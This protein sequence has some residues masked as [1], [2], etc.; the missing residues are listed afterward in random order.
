MA[1]G[2]QD[3]SRVKKVSPMR[4][5]RESSITHTEGRSIL[6]LNPG[7]GNEPYILATAIGREVSK[8][9]ASAG[10]EQPILVMPLFYGDRQRRILLEENPNDA[11][12]LYYDEQ[13]GGIL[14]DVMFE[15]G[16]F[17]Q[18]L[19][20]VNTHYDEVEKMLNNRYLVD[21][22]TVTAR[23]FAT[24]ESTELSPKNIIGVIEAGNRVPIK[25]P[26]RYFAFPEVLSRVLHEGM[27][28][29]ELGFSESDMKKLAKRMMKVEAAYSQVFVPWVST[30]SYQHAS[31][32]D[33]QPQSI[34]NRSRIYTPAMKANTAKTTGEV[35]QGVYIM[36]S[37]TGSAV[38]S[39]KALMHAAKEAGIKTYSPPWETIEGTEKMPP[40]VM[41][42]E[43][44]LAI[45]GRSGWGTGWQAMQLE[46]PWFV[47]P[48]QK[49]DDPEIYFNNKT[50]EALKLGK[51]IGSQEISGEELR[52]LAQEISPGLNS[53]ND[54]IRQK[55]G[56]T[57]GIDYIANHIFDDLVSKK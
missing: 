8:K 18:H 13:F 27:Q 54:A 32:L 57:N 16:D 53:L 44:I 46:K 2:E 28:H 35:D 34:D 11:S 55:F 20:Q 49:G 56:T 3:N 4:N 42:D 22:Q 26:H 41:A 23:S 21:T 31:G 47:A 50:I 37:G 51:V 38:E 36:F 17:K 10:M 5:L 29:P 9:F 15:S 40:S 43:N 6:V 14:K 52:R 48:Y 7:H 30:F 19:A 12:L 25:V 1:E 33:S 24:Q 45:M 39:N